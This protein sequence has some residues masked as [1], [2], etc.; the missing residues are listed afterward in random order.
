MISKKAA[1][2]GLTD[3][4]FAISEDIGKFLQKNGNICFSVNGLANVIGLV[5]GEI[6]ETILGVMVLHHRIAFY[7]LLNGDVVYGKSADYGY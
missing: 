6:L 1:V 3:A 2:L 7:K 4:H 5:G